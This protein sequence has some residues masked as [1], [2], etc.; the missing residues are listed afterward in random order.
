M[1]IC[2]PHCGMDPEST[3]GGETYEREL[4]RHL[5]ARGAVVDILLARH[6]RHPDDVPNWIVHRLPIGRGLRWPVAMLL[7]PPI[8]ARLH[9][10]TRFDLLRA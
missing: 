10:K 6:K 2:S 9:A 8:I 3:S 5:A 7:L 1:R 4:L